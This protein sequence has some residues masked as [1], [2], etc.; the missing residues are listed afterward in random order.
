MDE[1]PSL[2]DQPLLRDQPNRWALLVFLAGSLYACYLLIEPFVQPIILA[3]LIGMLTIPLHERVL[4]K[5]NGR[6]NIA[7]LLS[8]VLLTL[9][10]LIPTIVVLAAILKQGITYS[11]MVKDWATAENVQDLFQQPWMLELKAWLDRV[12]PADALNPERIRSQAL[13][14]ASGAG[15]QFAGVSTAMLGSVT[16][17]VVDFGLVLFVL[18]FV[19]RDHNKL[20]EFIRHALPLSR[21]QEDALLKEVVDVSKSALLG[22]FL[23][24]ITQGFVGGFGFYLAGIPA[25]FWGSMMAVSSLIP[26]VGTALVW[27][28][29][30]IYLFIVGETGWGIFMVVWGVVVIGSVDNFLRP[31]FMQGASMGTAVVFFSLLGG[32]HV[33]GLAGLIYGPIIFAIALVF[34]RLYENE[35]SDFLESQD[36]N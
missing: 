19:L 23:T 13:A 34:F 16:T 20:F 4:A 25:L 28:P 12:L 11:L 5:L 6:H 7:S 27:V 36:K 26:V 33:F 15:K 22:S 10:L 35:F 8:V 9:V 21:S 3:I 30:A 14:V 31:L 1:K 24:A 17:F 29:A 2:K 18:F 32:L